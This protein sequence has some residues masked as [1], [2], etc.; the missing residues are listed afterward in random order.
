[1]SL[2]ECSWKA[3]PASIPAPNKYVLDEKD[4]KIATF[5]GGDTCTIIGD[6]TLPTGTTVYW[7]IKLLNSPNNG[8]YV[9]VGV[10]PADI[11]QSENNF[12]KCGWY[13]HCGDSTL[14]SG[15]PHKRV[16]QKFG[17]TKEKGQH[18]QK[19][20]T[21]RV[22]MNMSTGSLSITV[23]GEE[24]GTPYEKIPLDKPLVPCVILKFRNDSV[25]INLPV[26]MAVSTL[27][28]T[29]DRYRGS[30]SPN[31][32]T[33]P[34]KATK[35][36]N[37]QYCTVLGDKEIPANAVSTWNVKIKGKDSANGM[38]FYI[39]VAPSNIN[40][41]NGYNFKACG[42]YYACLSGSL[43]SG[44]PQSVSGKEYGPRKKEGQYVR[45]DDVV[46]VVMDTTKGEL[47]FV[48]GGVNL[49]VAF[50]NI[51]LD[52]PLKP[53]ALMFGKGDTVYVVDK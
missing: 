43:F 29:W 1:M 5:T 49:G 41:A 46:G 28:F 8:S 9:Y 48:V 51:P 52:K 15:P 38:G 33:D 24:Y 36:D 4:P 47:S 12:F 22:T 17:P 19:D 45:N 23:N 7:N 39:G 11:S 34:K 50:D 53:C 16:G 14:F 6:K 31:Y 13:F 20:G 42:W 44:P 21:V 3:C 30:S 32:V 37:Y 18:V 10:A 26:S 35:L 27:D 2:F 25:G 40:Q